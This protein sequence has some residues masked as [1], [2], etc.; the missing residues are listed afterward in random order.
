M[1]L[2]Y[3]LLGLIWQKVIQGINGAESLSSNLSY[4][5]I[6]TA[7]FL[8]CYSVILAGRQESWSFYSTVLINTL[9][10]DSLFNCFRFR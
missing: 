2:S 1:I 8:L 3:A 10:G 5:R 4:F 9:S 7:G 6:Y